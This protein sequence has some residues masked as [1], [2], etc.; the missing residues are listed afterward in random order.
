M[1][2]LKGTA[3]TAG[4]LAYLPSLTALRP[5]RQLLAPLLP[6]DLKGLGRHGHVA[7]TYDDGPD[8]RSTPHFLDLLSRHDARVTFFLLGEH[9]QA[10]RTLVTEMADAGHELGIH[11]WDHLC[12]AAKRPGVLPDQIRRTRDLL[13]DIGGR[14]VRWYR[15]PYGV[16]T[17]ESML[18]A[19]RAGLRTALWSAWGRDWERRSTPASITRTV[20]RQLRTGGTV[21]L[22]DTDRTA[23][24]GSW[25]RTLAASETLL[26]EWAAAGTEVGSLS[27]HFA[28]PA[29]AA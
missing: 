2:N 27:A 29:T 24:P 20:R 9:L 14:P 28:V 26:S 7:L 6:T 11:G 25:W 10:N 22:H 15:P 21:L 4:A 5:V 18:T 13:E 12:V 8:P 23:A 3:L 16:S 17:T 19:R 1:S